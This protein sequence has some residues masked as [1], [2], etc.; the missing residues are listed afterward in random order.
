MEICKK[1]RFSVNERTIDNA[2]QLAAKASICILVKGV[3][4]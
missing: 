3:R 1:A 4:A 2:I